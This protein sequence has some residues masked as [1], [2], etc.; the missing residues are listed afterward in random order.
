MRKS[1]QKGRP[2]LPIG[3]GESPVAVSEEGRTFRVVVSGERRPNVVHIDAAPYVS[4][5]KSRCD[6]AVE[7]FGDTPKQVFFFVEL[8]GGDVLKAL[9]QLVYT[10]EHLKDYCHLL[11]YG[12]FAVRHACVVASHGP[13]PQCQHPRNASA[14]VY[15]ATRTLWFSGGENPYESVDGSS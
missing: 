11:N 5:L 10:A 12:K 13:P 1:I 9:D 7:V 2:K 3:R 8:K 15:G 6:Y 14:E 4:L